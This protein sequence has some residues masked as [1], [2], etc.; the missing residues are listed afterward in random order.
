MYA[1]LVC[2]GFQKTEQWR[3]IQTLR[4]CYGLAE[5]VLFAAGRDATHGVPAR[6]HV[7]SKALDKDQIIRL[8]DRAAGHG[9]TRCF[10]SSGSHMRCDL[11]E[12]AGRVIVVNKDTCHEVKDGCIGEVWITGR[13]K[14]QGY[15]NKPRETAAT[16]R[17]KLLS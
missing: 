7:E 5:N 16:F 9:A 2:V 1:L 8:V 14:A 15:W 4:P 13:S 10:V 11:L 12:A 17:A 6:I 3:R